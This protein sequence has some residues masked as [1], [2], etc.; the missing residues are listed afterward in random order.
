M[1]GTTH[2][3]EEDILKEKDVLEHLCSSNP[4]RAYR[5]HSILPAEIQTLPLD[6]CCRGPQEAE[7]YFLLHESYMTRKSIIYHMDHLIFAISE[8]SVFKDFIFMWQSS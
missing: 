7:E 6:L 1:S 4:Q 3:K 2:K 5:E 8:L